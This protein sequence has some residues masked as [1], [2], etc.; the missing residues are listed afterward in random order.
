M[1]PDTS[2]RPA[3]PP[4]AGPAIPPSDPRAALLQ[5]PNFRWMIGGSAL[6][7]LGDQFT[8][9]ALPGAGAADDGRHA[10][11]GHRAGPHQRATRAVHPDRRRAGGPPF[12]QA[13][14]DDHQIRQPGAAGRPGGAG[15]CGHAVVVDGVRAVAGHWAGHGL[16][17]SGRHGHDALGGGP[18]LAGCQRNQPGPAA[19]DDVPGAL[20]RGAADCTVWRGMRPGR[21]PIL[22]H[23]PTPPASA[24]PLRWMR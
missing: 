8:L 21:L 14:A 3:Q 18:H 11:A 20:A 9:I 6:S 4:G 24:W 19:A 2:P 13:S 5:D 16:Q 15:V 7:M 12:A 1:R 17:H 10:G 22:R 23:M